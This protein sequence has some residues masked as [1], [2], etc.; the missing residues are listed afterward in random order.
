MYCQNLRIVDIFNKIAKALKENLPF[1]AYKHP[2]GNEIK[3]FFQQDNQLYTTENFQENGFVFAPFDDVNPAILFPL[4][5]SEVITSPLVEDDLV[6]IT[7]EDSSL[8]IS[9]QEKTNHIDLIQKGIDFLKTTQNKKVVLS[10]KLELE[11]SDFE[12]ITIFKKLLSA[13]N[14]AT[15]YIWFHPKV[16]IWLGATPETLLKVKD[17]QFSTMAL[18]GTQLYSGSLDVV[19]KNKEKQEQQ[20]VTDYIVEKLKNNVTVSDVKTIKAGSLVHLC[21][22]IYGNLSQQFSL[23]KLIKLLHP[24]PAVCGFPQ[25]KTKVFILDNEHYNREFYTGFFGEINIETASSLF[26]NLRCMQVLKESIVIYVGGGIT[27]D[28]NP[29]KEWDETVAK[30]K[31]M[32]KVLV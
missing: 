6:A 32:L 29:L 25:Q 2:Q 16:G 4:A 12:L 11:H 21:T 26:V 1:V 22:N 24:T 13:Y 20:F 8:V 10:R 18:A 19:W 9:E 14:N 5:K 28:S 7:I 15:V 3:G 31:V 30:S 17:N 23:K 27:V